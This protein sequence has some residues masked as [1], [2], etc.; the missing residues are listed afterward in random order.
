MRKH[1][2]NKNLLHKFKANLPEAFKFPNDFV[3]RRLLNEY[4]ALFMARG[5][6]VVPESVIFASEREVSDWQAKIPTANLTLGGF[7]I[8][9]QT[10]AMTNLK[11]AIAEAL[12]NNLIITP[13]GADSARRNYAQTVE[14]WTSRVNPALS[15]WVKEG[16]LSEAA[17]KKIRELPAFEQV[18]EIFKLEDEGI[19]FS[20]D[21]LKSIIYSVAPPGTSQHLSMLALDVAEFNEPKVRNVLAA[22]GWFQ[23]VISDLPHFTFLGAAEDELESFGLKKVI[24]DE[25][26]FWIP[27]L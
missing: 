14:L 24:N 5:G 9:L 17:A 16:K 26:V 7:V 27:N 22:H 25:R 13:R 1:E 11:K 3:G 18:S 8:E 21:L 23:T 20:K 19:F 4:G 10:A 15:H 2:T 6:A 12:E